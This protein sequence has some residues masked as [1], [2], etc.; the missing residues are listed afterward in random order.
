MLIINTIIEQISDLTHIQ[1]RFLI[2][3]FSVLLTFDGRATWANLSRY[4][5]FSERTMRRH[6]LQGLDFASFNSQ[7]NLNRDVKIIAIDATTIKKSGKSTYGLSKFWSS[8]D[9]K[10]VHGIEY[11]CVALID[12]NSQGAFHLS[13][14]QTPPEGNRIDFYIT[15]IQS[16]KPNFPDSAKHIVADGYYAKIKFHK[17]VQ[18]LGLNLITKLRKD[19]RF[20][21]PPPPKTGKKGRPKI[22]GDRVLADNLAN[23]ITLS[24]GIVLKY[25]DLYVETFRQQCMVVSVFHNNKLVMYL[26]S[27]DNEMPAEEVFRFYHARFQHE[28]LFRDAKQHTGLGECQSRDQKSLDFHANA[29]LTAVSFA[30]LAADSKQ[31]FSIYSQKRENLNQ[32]IAKNIFQHFKINPEILINDDF[33]KN[34]LKIGCIYS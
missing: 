23:M 14:S 28:I 5:C 18:E 34:I 2:E 7:I 22:K 10:A 4:S 16:L 9:G 33:R 3:L 26:V 32:L 17:A 11:S 31:P 21:L 24:E 1:R 27:T 8:C 20:F 19:A 6:A 13:A 30:R 12:P 25:Q 29:A 15:Q